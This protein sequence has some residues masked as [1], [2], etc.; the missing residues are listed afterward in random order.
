M[1]T[2]DYFFFQLILIKFTNRWTAAYLSSIDT[3][4]R[5]GRAMSTSSIGL[6]SRKFTRKPK[7]NR[8]RNTIKST[9]R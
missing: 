9:R 6:A 2:L 5:S 4:Q 3:S 8:T 1:P 7:A